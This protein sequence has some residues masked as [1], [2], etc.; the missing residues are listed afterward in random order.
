M[1]LTWLILERERER[2]RERAPERY[3]LP[4]DLEAESGVV[5]ARDALAPGTRSTGGAGTTIVKGIETEIETETE[6]ETETE[7]GTG[8]GAGVGVGVGIEG[9]G[10]RGRGG[11]GERGEKMYPIP[12]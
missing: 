11:T 8:I 6:T 12:S 1:S 10:G 4:S 2:E 7:R 9:G 5:T 3:H